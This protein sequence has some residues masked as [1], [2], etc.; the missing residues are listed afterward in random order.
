MGA[1]R[2]F[3]FS[4]ALALLIA[5]LLCGCVTRSEADAR[6]TAA[7]SAGQKAAYAAIGVDPDTSIAIAGPVRH[8]RVP[9][10]AGLTLVQA[11]ATADYT[12]RR[13]PREITITRHGQPI[14]VDPNNLLNGHAVLLEPGDTITLL[15][16]K[17]PPKP[18]H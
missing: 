12:G 18:E 16:M 1:S 6:E 15:E 2:K 4:G 9:W 5:M 11:I 8:A 10:V 3:F 17:P 13:N 7:Y 14:S